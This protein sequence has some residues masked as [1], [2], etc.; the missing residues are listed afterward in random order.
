MWILGRGKL[1]K[2]Y[3]QIAEEN[4]VISRIKFIDWVDEPSKYLNTADILVCPSRIEPLGNIIIEGWCHKIPVVA[5]NIMGPKKLIKHKVNGMKFE[6]ENIDELVK[7]LKELDSNNVL[8][9]KMINNA[10]KDYQNHFSERK[11]INDF[12]NFFWKI[13]NKCA[14]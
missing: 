2:H 8:K 6:L 5:S 4:N 14:E 7:C 12:K 10:Y 13:K 1:K 9:R 11:V 3:I